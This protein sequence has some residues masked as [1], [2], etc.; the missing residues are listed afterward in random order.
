MADEILVT[1]NI[2]IQPMSSTF[3]IPAIENLPMQ[4]D[5]FE[6]MN[7]VRQKPACCKMTGN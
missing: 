1:P 2:E 3:L 4:I 6:Y 7:L 5:A